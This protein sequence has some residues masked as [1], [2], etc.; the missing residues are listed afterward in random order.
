MRE[1][2]FVAT[3]TTDGREIFFLAAKSVQKTTR[4]FMKSLNNSFSVISL[5]DF[6]KSIVNFVIWIVRK[7]SG[8]LGKF[9]DDLEGFGKVWEV[10]RWFKVL[11][12]GVRQPIDCDATSQGLGRGQ[13]VHWT[14]A[15]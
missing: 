2:K 5:T 3:V 12:L 4:N 10:S 8:L 14:D 7:V 15:H 13:L 11:E 6:V 1:L 9:P